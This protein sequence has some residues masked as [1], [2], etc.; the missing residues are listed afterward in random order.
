MLRN[1]V[2]LYICKMYFNYLLSAL[3]LV[4]KM[5]NDHCGGILCSNRIAYKMIQQ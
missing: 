2:D 1:V 4:F 3:I 5:L